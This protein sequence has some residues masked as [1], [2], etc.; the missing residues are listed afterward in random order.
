MSPK[1]FYSVRLTSAIYRLHAVV[2]MLFQD[3]GRRAC[4]FSAKY[5]VSDTLAVAG[6][7]LHEYNMES[8]KSRSLSRNHCLRTHATNAD[9]QLQ[10]IEIESKSV[11]AN[12]F[13]QVDRICLLF[14]EEYGSKWKKPARVQPRTS[15]F[16]IYSSLEALSKN[17]SQDVNAIK[18]HESGWRRAIRNLPRREFTFSGHP[19]SFS[20]LSGHLGRR[21]GRNGLR[22]ISRGAPFHSSPGRLELDL[23]LLQVGNPLL[24]IVPIDSHVP[25]SRDHNRAP[26]RGPI[27]RTDRPRRRTAEPARQ[28]STR[29]RS[30]PWYPSETLINFGTGTPPPSLRP[31]YRTSCKRVG[32]GLKL[33]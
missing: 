20:S 10:R 30:G 33:V 7:W 1:R 24:P 6:A 3:C 26:C 16:L 27:R 5:T 31:T 25:S 2:R 19:N 21:N 9:L 8:R 23:P 29:V 18:Y 14:V 22:W 13:P 17:I 12:R 32:R 28:D 11:K 4:T 15:A